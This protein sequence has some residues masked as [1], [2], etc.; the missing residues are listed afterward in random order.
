MARKKK[1]DGGG[2]L[3]TAAEV[4]AATVGIAATAY[5]AVQAYREGDGTDQRD[6]PRGGRGQRRKVPGIRRTRSSPTRPLLPR[7]HRR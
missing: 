3:T 2:A 4:A 6:G 7:P 5:K 1:G